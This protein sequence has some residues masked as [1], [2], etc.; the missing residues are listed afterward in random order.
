MPD[1]LSIF[2]QGRETLIRSK[3]VVI[4]LHGGGRKEIEEKTK[5]RWNKIVEPRN[6]ELSSAAHM[7]KDLLDHEVDVYLNINN[8]V[9]FAFGFGV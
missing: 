3:E 1:I 5:E 2:E 4:R 6:K 9:T 8:H 7:I